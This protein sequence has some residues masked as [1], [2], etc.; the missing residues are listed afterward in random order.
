[1]RSRWK[2]IVFNTLLP[3]IGFGVTVLATNP[4]TVAAGVGAIGVVGVAVDVVA[5]DTAPIVVDRK[6]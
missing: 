5:A 3:L 1:M 4:L 2:S 6:P